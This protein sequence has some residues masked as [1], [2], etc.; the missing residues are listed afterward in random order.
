LGSYSAKSAYH[1]FFNGSVT[2]EP[3]RRIWKCWAPSKCKFF[4]WRAI[5]N[6]C[7]TAD[8]LARQGMSHLEKCPLCDQEEETIQ[9]LLTRCVFSRQVWFA[10]LS[11][12]EI[13]GATPCSNEQSFTQWWAKTAHKVKECKKGVNSLVILTAWVI[14]K[15]HN[16]CVFEGTAP[17]I[18]EVLRQFREEYQLW[19][20]AGAKNLHDLKLHRV[21]A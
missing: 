7:W 10:V 11:P 2:F 4:I 9:H 13:R 20:L 12:L 16:A 6:H 3:W 21:G 5:Q 19:C 14:W 1:A 18:S 8:R 17:S 15:H